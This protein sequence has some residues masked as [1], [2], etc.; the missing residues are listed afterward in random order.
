MQDGE[1]MTSRYLDVLVPEIADEL[2]IDCRAFSDNWV[3]QLAQGSGRAEIFG[4]K[5]G[6]NGAAAA[7][8]AGDKVATSEVL[9]RAHIPAIEHVLVHNYQGNLKRYGSVVGEVVAKPLSG[10]G[11]WGVQ[12]FASQSEAEQAIAQSSRFAWAISPYYNIAREIRIIMLDGEILLAY[13]KSEPAMRDGLRMF[14]LGAGAKPLDIE[15]HETLASMVDSTMAALN[16]RLASV[17]VVEVD[18]AGY[19]IMEVNDGIM[20]EHYM[21]QS[22]EHRARGKVVYTKIIKALISK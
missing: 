11:G 5:F 1:V 18:R 8:I 13:E 16:L 10:S 4:Y 3:Y 2:G 22:V 6:I 17:D 15:P 21:N 7:A 12:K 19:Y 20:M 9:K 14:N